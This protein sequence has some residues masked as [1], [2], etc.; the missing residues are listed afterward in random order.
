[1]IYNAP[2]K[3]TGN[4]FGDGERAVATMTGS[5]ANLLGV[6]LGFFLPKFFVSS[7]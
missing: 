5:S 6:V 4:W 2:V 3:V 7:A 1:L